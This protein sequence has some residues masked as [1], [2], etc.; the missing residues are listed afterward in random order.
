MACKLTKSIG[1]KSCSYAVAGAAALYLAN[2]F[3]AVEGAASVEG[4]IA[5]TTDEDGVITA[6]KLP[7]GESF[8]K[9]QAAQ[10]T[11][12]FSDA[13]TTGGSG[14]KFRTHTVNATLSELDTD[15]LSEG[16]ALSLGRFIAIVVDNG[17][18]VILLGRTGGLTAS[19]FDYN[20]GAAAADAMGWTH[21]LAGA[22]G[23][24]IKELSSVA[25]VT[26]IQEDTVIE[27]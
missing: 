25:V 4:A 20:S 27:E 3:P 12:S 11:L 18:N 16:D 26:P 1:G 15:I 7:A 17:G 2:W 23:E 14:A 5:Y 9:V 10:D 21:V 19:Q 22:Q 6:I 24:L 13:L 8:Y